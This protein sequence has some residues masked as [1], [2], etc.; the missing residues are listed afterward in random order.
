MLSEPQ[1]PI[2]TLAHLPRSETGCK[3]IGCDEPINCTG[4]ESVEGDTDKNHE[5]HIFVFSDII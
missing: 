3:L 5:P 1:L 2:Q 4:W